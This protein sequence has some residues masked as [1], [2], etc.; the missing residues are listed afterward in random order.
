MEYKS[1]LKKPRDKKIIPSEKLET[2]ISNN[3][4]KR[5]DFSASFKK[6]LEEHDRLADNMLKAAKEYDERKKRMKKIV[7]D[8]QII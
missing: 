5:F 1:N 3:E 8:E 7:E 6:I 4:N 2:I